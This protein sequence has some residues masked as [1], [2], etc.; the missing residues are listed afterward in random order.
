MNEPQRSEHFPF[1]HWTNN[2]DRSCWTCAYA[3]GY[4]GVQLWCERFRIV[5]IDAR[6]CWERGA[7]S[8]S[9]NDHYR[10]QT[11]KLGIILERRALCAAAVDWDWKVAA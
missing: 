7:G 2:A 8:T 4:N 5:V 10:R 11:F 6:G 1:T 9:Q 3:I